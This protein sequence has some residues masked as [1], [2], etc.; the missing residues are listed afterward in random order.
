MK[1]I[2]DEI[3][4]EN[5]IFSQTQ[6]TEESS[7]EKLKSDLSTMIDRLDMKERK[8]EKEKMTSEVT[9]LVREEIAKIKPVQNIIERTIEKQLEQVI[10]HV[11]VPVKLPNPVLP[12]PQKI[13]EIIREVRIEAPKDNKSYAEKSDL[14][15][16]NEDLKKEIDLLKSYVEEMRQTTSLAMAA[17]GGSGV[18]GIPA[19][20]GNP[21]NYVLT[22]S[23]GRA[24]WKVSTGSGGSSQDAYTTSNVTTTRSLS[25]TSSTIDVLYNVVASLIQ[26]LQGAGI[27]Q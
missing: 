9:A 26:S 2:F 22:I 17:M 19:P 4:E 25:A 27:I 20:E 16:I 24:I 23:K 1:D 6:S 15:K 11:Q 3:A 12:P 21:D 7:I 13:K 18:I 10:K 8:A 5:D 14:S